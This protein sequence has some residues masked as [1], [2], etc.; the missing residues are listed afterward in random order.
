MLGLVDPGDILEGN[1]PDLFS[2]KARP[3]L[4]EAHRPTAPALHLA[5]EKYPNADQQ[6]HGK[7][8]N[9]DAKQRGHVFIDRGRGYPHVLLGQ[10]ADKIGVVRSIGG[11][12]PAVGEMTA[13]IVALNRDIGNL[14][15]IDVIKKIRKR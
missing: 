15:T 1:P 4:A 3:A 13:D 5:H 6:Q 8:G 12:R 11:E 10:P 7:P 9:Q 14:A 2:Q